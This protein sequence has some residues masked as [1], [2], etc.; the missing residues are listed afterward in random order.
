MNER[1]AQ[2]K[3]TN[4][5]DTCMLPD[6]K[7]VT[8]ADIYTDTS[9]CSQAYPLHS[10]PRQVAGAPLTGDVLACALEPV[11]PSSSM[12]TVRFSD[13]QAARLRQIFPRGVCDWTVP[14]RGQVAPDGTWQVFDKP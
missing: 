4:A 8:G 10:S 2:T 1:L 9:P 7:V 13:E 5:V 12:Y 11:D 6:G 3:P 14:G